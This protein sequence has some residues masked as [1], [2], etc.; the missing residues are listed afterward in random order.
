MVKVNDSESALPRKGV[1]I[2]SLFCGGTFII[3]VISDVA[4][5]RGFAEY[6]AN[7]VN[8]YCWPADKRLDW[9]AS[10]KVV[11]PF[12]VGTVKELISL[13]LSRLTVG[14]A[15]H[16][17]LPVVILLVICPVKTIVS[18]TLNYALNGLILTEGI[19]VNKMFTL[20][21]TEAVIPAALATK[22]VNCKVVL[23]PA[24]AN[25]DAGEE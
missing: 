3:I 13:T 22:T 19:N 7:N 16:V 18:P 9:N 14:S 5:E 23:L 8:V 15:L 12:K 20:L 1:T 17:A 6:D 2:K 11:K 4:K 10:G 25:N 24:T 21:V